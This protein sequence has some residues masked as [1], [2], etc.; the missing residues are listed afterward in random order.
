MRKYASQIQRLQHELGLEVSQFPWLGISE[1]EV[2]ENNTEHLND[3]DWEEE[4]DRILDSQL[5]EFRR[6]KEDDESEP[7]F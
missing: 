3:G 4:L 6:M 2:L 1:F 7:S 5:D